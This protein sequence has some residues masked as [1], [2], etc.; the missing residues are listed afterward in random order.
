MDGVLR[1]YCD[2]TE[3]H[4]HPLLALDPQFLQ[5]NTMTKS[6]MLL[7]QNVSSTKCTMNIINFYVNNYM[8]LYVQPC[9]TLCSEMCRHCSDQKFVIFNWL[10]WQRV[11]T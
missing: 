4:N 7:D 3:Y 8:L 11:S 6:V 1:D 5:L 2:G 9:F 10:L